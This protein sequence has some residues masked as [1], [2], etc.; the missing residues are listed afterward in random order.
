VEHPQ[1]PSSQIK[2]IANR[3]PLLIRRAYPGWKETKRLLL[4]GASHPDTYYYSIILTVTDKGGLSN[5]QEVRLYPDC[6]QDHAVL[7]YLGR[8]AAQAIRYQLTGNPTRSYQVEGSS[9]LMT[10]TSVTNLQPVAGS[11][12]FTDPA[13]ATAAFRFYR[14]VSFP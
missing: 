10:W 11:T 2:W 13:A 4:H 6:P 12:E 1:R 3:P 8:N 9:N 14:A 5:T 7:K